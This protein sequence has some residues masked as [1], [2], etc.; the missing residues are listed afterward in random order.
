LIGFVSVNRLDPLFAAEIGKRRIQNRPYSNWRWHLDEV[1]VRINGEAR[2]LWRAVNHEGEVFE[3]F[4]TKRRER[5]AA[6]QETGR[7]LNNSP[8][9]NGGNLPPDNQQSISFVAP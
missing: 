3:A 8:W 5:K 2:Y 7:W 4:V 1:F 9:R 6:G